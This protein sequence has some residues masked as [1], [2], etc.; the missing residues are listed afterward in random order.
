[1]NFIKLLSLLCFLSLESGFMVS[2][3]LV[4]ALAFICLPLLIAS[5]QPKQRS[6]FLGPRR[7]ASF[8]A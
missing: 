6:F 7:N 2:G 4:D 3:V 8:S 5:S 1:M